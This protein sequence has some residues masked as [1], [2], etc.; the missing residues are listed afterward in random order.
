MLE[1]VVHAEDGIFNDELLMKAWKGP[2]SS[3]QQIPS[4]CIVD[5]EA[6]LRCVAEGERK[7]IFA[8]EG[9]A[10]DCSSSLEAEKCHGELWKCFQAV[11]RRQKE[12]A[13]L[14]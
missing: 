13:E 10:G 2:D 1:T 3:N 12:N 7:V 4:S 8:K 14:A 5:R 6:T 11:K 9:A